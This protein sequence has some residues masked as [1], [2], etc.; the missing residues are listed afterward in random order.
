MLAAEEDK[1]YG[2]DIINHF[3]YA[4]YA[5][6]KDLQG[7]GLGRYIHEL[8][9]KRVSISS[10]RTEVADAVS[11]LKRRAAFSFGPLHGTM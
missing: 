7:T 3:R 6:H 4:A 1:A 2:K 5:I 8:N 9:V 10:D 11:R